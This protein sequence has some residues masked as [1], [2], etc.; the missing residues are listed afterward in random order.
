[1]ST[2]RGSLD[3]DEDDDMSLLD[4]DE[5]SEVDEE[6]E[7]IIFKEPTIDELGR[8]YGTGRRKTSVARVWIKE[9]SGEF[10]VNDR[11]FVN[12]FQAW[13]RMHAL[14]VFQASKTA[15]HFDVWCTVKGGGLSGQAGAIRLGISRALEAF[16][17][18]LRPI[19]SQAGMLTRDSR[20]V[21]R[22]KPGQK[23]ARKQF[24]VLLT[25]LL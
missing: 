3:D 21:E 24:Q 14:E 15:G 22:K 19:L 12:Y 23:K 18:S 16:N 17:P 11:E 20:R 1:M 10:I 6:E 7:E 9:G 2:M 4:D 8:A 13:Q 5:L 25:F